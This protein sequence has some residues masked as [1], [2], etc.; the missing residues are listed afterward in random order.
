MNPLPRIVIVSAS[1]LL[2]DGV[3]AALRDGAWRVAIGAAD[4]DADAWVLLDDGVTV[5]GAG[6][7]SAQLSSGVA[8]PKLRAAVGAVLAGLSVRETP[9]PID[10][11]EREPL[12]P[13]EIEVFELLGKGLSNRD[14]AGVLGI[15]AH[16]AKY[17]VAQILAKVGAATRA[18]AVREGLRH[19]WIGL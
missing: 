16:T 10:I 7:A 15:S 5:R 8:A 9:W 18:E 12:T 6:G 13:R 19:G 11:A 2:A 1:P 3:A 17:H 14:I 4:D